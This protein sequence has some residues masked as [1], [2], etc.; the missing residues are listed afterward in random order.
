M[1]VKKRFHL[2]YP[3]L[4]TAFAL[5]VVNWLVV[6]TRWAG[7][8]SFYSDGLWAILFKLLYFGTW[9]TLVF[10]ICARFMRDE[11]AEVLWRRAASHLA[12]WLVLLPP[13]AMIVLAFVGEG[14]LAD[15]AQSQGIT[16]TS[17][18]GDAMLASANRAQVEFM[19]MVAAVYMAT[20][21]VPTL[22]AGLLLW[23]KWRDR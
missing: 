18:K 11:Y 21:F 6:L 2:Y 22:F 13:A 16:P 8:H 4:A 1:T 7:L 23:Q 19:T 9:L 20:A 5:Q 12:Y 17:E 10:C 3:L 15:L 14:I